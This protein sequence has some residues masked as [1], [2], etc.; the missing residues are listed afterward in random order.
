MRILL[1]II[2]KLI[3]IG[4]IFTVTMGIGL[5]LY[6]STLL[7]N[8][9]TV[10]EIRQIPLNIPLRIFSSDKKLIGEYG[11]ERRIPLSLD[12][13]PPLLIDAVLVTEDDQFYHHTGVDFPGL[14]RAAVSN[15]L[16]RSRG[17]GASTITMQVARNFFLNPEKTYTRKLKEILLAFNMERALTKDEILELYLNKIFLGHRA[18]GF[19]A[20]A[21]VYYGDDLLNLSV[22]E[23]AMLAGLPKAP[24]RNNPISNPKRAKE[25]RFYVLKRLHE[26]GRIDDLSFDT[27]SNAPITAKRHIADVDIQAPYISEMARKLVYDRFGESVYQHGYNVTV[28]INSK[29]QEK[30]GQALRKG[31]LDY[32]LRHGYKGP[33]SKI[34]L[35][36]FSQG[37]RVSMLAEALDKFPASK[38]IIP[39]VVTEL[40]EKSFQGINQRG[41]VVTVEWENLAWARK[42]SSAN[43]R[44][45]ELKSTADILTIGDVIYVRELAE[46]K[47]MLSQ[48]PEVSG[49]LVSLNP[50][51]G[52]I[53]ALT[54]G[55]DY[56]LSKFNRATQA[57]RQPGSNIK[58]FIYSAALENGFTASSL[59]SAAPIV[60]DDTLEGVWRP[61]NYSK[62]FFGPTRLRK[63]LSLSLN[64]VSVRLLRAI[65]IDNTIDHL[66]GFG[67][68][69]ERLPRNLSLALGSTS[70]TPLN[71]ASCFAGFANGGK[72]VTPFLIE[73][74][75]DSEGNLVELS[76]AP[77]E[78]C[79]DSSAISGASENGVEVVETAV[80]A[81]LSGLEILEPEPDEPD[82]SGSGGNQSGR[83]ITPQNAY[84]MQSLLKQVI[85][86][87][88]GRRALAL[89]RSDLAGKTGTTNNFRDAWFSGFNPDVVTTVFVGFDDP[90]HLGKRESGASAALPIWVDFMG[91]VLQ[92][93]PEK[94]APIPEN[95]TTRFINKDSGQVTFPDDPD[96]FSEFFLVGTEPN[97]LPVNEIN[98][99]GNTGGSDANQSVSESLF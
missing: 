7:P 34:L 65:G 64:L 72:K 48:I 53:L 88:T 35:S 51:T 86:S 30:A 82:D 96:G 97:N 89:N 94:P 67:F 21:Q 92:D 17:Q 1:K 9:P 3:S 79:D 80:L 69:R 27:A 5:A 74:I 24:S 59:V 2:L 85:L 99:I 78:N 87:G 23:I 81:Q 70:I 68:D 49:A 91:R 98:P 8:L 50:N 39:A 84:L 93:F 47:W 19:A 36:E 14:A 77:C 55:F 45:P 6:A 31:L 18:Y 28:T 10:D 41:E 75:E 46:G 32:D 38:E 15:L 63:A 20:A 40:N 43:A 11:N 61:Q 58:P 71:L 76:P 66:A 25:R 56:Y 13:T 62:K 29:Y 16:S 54:G 22:P 90:S 37:N 44:G 33:V 4:F 12:K 26:L 73:K 83:A 42:Y 52:A 60:V 57:E 95:I